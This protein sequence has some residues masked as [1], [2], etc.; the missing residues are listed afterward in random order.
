MSS[1]A[2]ISQLKWISLFMVLLIV[3]ISFKPAVQQGGGLVNSVSAISAVQPQ[4]AKKA[5]VP[6]N[7][8]SIEV[9]ATG[10][11]AG[12]ESTGKDPGHPEYGI[13]FSGVKV[14]RDVVSTIAADT[15]VFPLGTIL[16]IPG[17]GYGVV[18]DT[19]SAIKG[20]IIDLYFVTKDQV[21]SLWGKKTVKVKLIKKGDGKITE[22]MLD[23][24]NKVYTTASSR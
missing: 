1:E 6:Y 10:Y 4:E 13:T 12:V 20:H 16:E 24:L 15:E 8:P 7:Q 18:A 14:R 17:Y 22:D 19:G 5:V 3:L 11:Y 23:H 21:Y 2:T 9:I